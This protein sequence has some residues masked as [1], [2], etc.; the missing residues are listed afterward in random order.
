MQ[1]T[2]KKQIFIRVFTH[3]YSKD[4]AAE[5]FIAPYPITDML[6]LPQSFKVIQNSRG[7]PY[8]AIS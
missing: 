3:Q 2:T 8:A 5:G 1:V 4:D 7:D 6:N